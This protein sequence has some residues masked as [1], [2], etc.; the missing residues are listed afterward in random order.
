MSYPTDKT[1][2][3][4]MNRKLR[5]LKHVPSPDA[6]REAAIEYLLNQEEKLKPP[7]IAGLRNHIGLTPSQFQ[8]LCLHP[9]Y[10][11]ILSSAASYIEEYIESGLLDGSIKGNSA[12][13]YLTNH[14]GWSTSKEP[15]DKRDLNSLTT[16]E[17]LKLLEASKGQPKAACLE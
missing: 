7:T 5:L 15:E 11:D 3:R 2:K 12:A 13:L 9:Q 8:N 17:L 10:S 4:E 1:A 16:E 6:V 14:F